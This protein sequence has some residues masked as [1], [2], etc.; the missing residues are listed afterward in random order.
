MPN[1]IEYASQSDINPSD[2]GI[3]AADNAG[4]RLGQYGDEIGRTFKQFGHM[5]ED[6]MAVMETS[7]LYKTGTELRINLQQKYAE[8][9]ALPQNRNDPHFGDRFMAEV[10]PQ[11][12]KWGSHA[13][14]DHGQQL[15]ATL[16]ANIRNE[17]F[18]HVASGQSAMDTAH[19]IDN[20][21]QTINSLGSGL[22]LDP[23]EA[24][25]S[26]TLGTAKDAIQGMTM[27]IPDVETRERVASELTSQ[28]APQLVIARYRG[29]AESIKNQV[30]ET[31]D[32]AKA[33]AYDQ[34]GKDIAGQVGFQYLKP[35]QQQQLVALRDEAVRQ[36]QELYRT[37]QVEVRRKQDEAVEGAVMQVESSM[38]QPNGAGGVTVAITPDHLRAMQQIV[39]LPGAERHRGAIEALGN[40]MHTATQ[41]QIEGKERTTDQQSFATLFSRVGSTS[42][43]LTK[44]EVD[45][46][47][48]HLSNKDWQFL[49]DSAA[50]SKLAQPK[51]QHAMT[52]LNHWLDTIVK[53]QIVKS[54]MYGATDP[55]GAAQFG[56]FS[57]YAQ[58][59]LRRF[60][61][62]GQDPEASLSV[63]TD[64]KGP[65]SYYRDMPRYMSNNKQGLANILEA[66]KPSGGGKLPAVPGS[67]PAPR[68][69]GESPEAYLKRTGQ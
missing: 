51:V 69:A 64:P 53:P 62:S 36:G 18:N 8:E 65:N 1:I 52:E 2:K 29:V 44:A 48:E 13:L 45:L 66:V 68:A 37:G 24:N 7:E 17:I 54:N 27:A 21:N 49:R 3:Q 15:A 9:S 26:R 55:A 60:I 11:L 16:K 58:D 20:G 56:Y 57:W 39:G 23:S 33:P 34:L 19:V 5:V 67:G 31:G 46:Q 38:F 4:R 47:R 14:T 10:G 22:L 61:D 25:L 40:A 32:A 12:D 59:R 35:E 6:H 63:L 41:D 30:A 50:D 28:A 42:N 43:P